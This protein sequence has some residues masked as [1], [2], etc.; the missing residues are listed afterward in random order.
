MA[1]LG[2]QRFDLWFDRKT[3][4]TLDGDRL[5][6]RPPTLLRSGL[7]LI[8]GKFRDDLLSAAREVIGTPPKSP[9]QSARICFRRL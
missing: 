6:S 4:F 2:E 7:D 8:Q 1:H 3:R 5:T 9:W